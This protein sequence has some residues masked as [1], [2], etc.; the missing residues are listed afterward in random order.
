MCPGDALIALVSPSTCSSVAANPQPASVALA[1]LKSPGPACAAAGHVPIT[2]P[3]RSWCSSN[4]QGN[5]SR[6]DLSESGK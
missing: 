3:L 4:N 5:E 2:W 6:R 1:A